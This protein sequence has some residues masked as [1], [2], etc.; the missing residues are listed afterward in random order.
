MEKR[1][2]KNLKHSYS[3][4]MRVVELSNQG[5]GSATISKEMQISETVVKNWLR[6]YRSKGF[7]GLEK[8]HNKL[9]S[10]EFKELVTRDI[11]NKHPSQ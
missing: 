10:I 7:S 3:E 11:L 6:I 5:Y 8:Q 1:K 4:K 9:L 2:R